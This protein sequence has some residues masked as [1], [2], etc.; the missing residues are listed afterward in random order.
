MKNKFKQCTYPWTGITID[1]NGWITL[2]CNT[3]HTKEL[4]HKI[5][6]IESLKDFFEGEEFEY[7]R[8][9][10]KKHG[11]ENIKSCH[12]CLISLSGIH[13][14][15]DS[16]YKF[17]P[18]RGLQYLEFST[19]NTCNQTCVTCDSYFS[20]KWQKLEH[21]F[22]RG[23][24]KTYR[25]S[26]DDID[27]IIEVLPGLKELQLK[28][29]EPLM[30]IRNVQILDALSKVNPECKVIICTNGQNISRTFLDVIK[31]N[32]KQYVIAVS[33]DGINEIYNWIRGGD[34]NKTIIT[35]QKIYDETEIV[36]DI[37]P[38]I[39]AFNLSHLREIYDF[40][41]DKSYAKNN[42]RLYNIVTSPEWA[43]PMHIY[44]QE[45]LDKVVSGQFNDIRDKIDCEAL[46]QMKSTYNPEIYEQYIQNTKIMDKIRR[47][48]INEN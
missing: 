34:W 40:F 35:M 30:D 37:N 45:Q 7:V 26:E 27:K 4:K 8:S 17:I 3:T 44:H 48:S 29:G 28:G 24:V 19:S 25:F 47:F 41:I 10:F 16:S 5:S 18:D 38:C 43:S 42:F 14:V 22:G 46:Y 6:D 13:T 12:K 33:I 11:W 1:P 2:C 39:S 21:L 20:T 32:P 31:K 9:K 23:A 15:I 36:F